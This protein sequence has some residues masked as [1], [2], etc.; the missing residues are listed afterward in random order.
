MFC[1]SST[2]LA[3]KILRTDEH[4]QK[5][6]LSFDRTAALQI[7]QRLVSPLL[8]RQLI[9]ACSRFWALFLSSV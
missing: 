7:S 2:V 6:R 1:Q 9:N 4:A 8:S 5:F 3:M